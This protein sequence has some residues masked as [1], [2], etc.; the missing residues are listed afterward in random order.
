VRLFTHTADCQSPAPAVCILEFEI[1]WG[2]GDPEILKKMHEAKQGGD[3]GDGFALL[4][5]FFTRHKEKG[6]KQMPSCKHVILVCAEFHSNIK[7]W[8]K[9]GE[10]TQVVPRI[11]ENALQFGNYVGQFGPSD[12]GPCTA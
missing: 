11:P 2:D 3:R 6:N 7:N 4:E 5:H 10:N 1:E 8:T 9:C 12:V